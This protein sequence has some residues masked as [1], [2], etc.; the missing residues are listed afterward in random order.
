[1]GNRVVSAKRL[2]VCGVSEGSVG[3]AT[4]FP[5]GLTYEEL[6]NWYWVANWNNATISCDIAASSSATDDNS[7][8][9]YASVGFADSIVSGYYKDGSAI[10]IT[11]EKQLVCSGIYASFGKQFSDSKC[12][13][14]IDGKYACVNVQVGSTIVID[15]NQV[16]LNEGLYYP[17]VH[18][19]VGGNDDLAF[20]HPELEQGSNFGMGWSTENPVENPFPGYSTWFSIPLSVFN[21]TVDIY[22]GIFDYGSGSGYTHTAP[23]HLSL[24]ARRWWE[25][26]GTNNYPIYNPFT[27]EQLQDPFS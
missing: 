22:G 6:L 7:H 21:K 14:P 23:S 3:V 5:I 17:Y 13:D 15:F 25:Y 1:M 11:S 12:T 16:N 19:E 2:P 8:T 20:F 4:N 18:A 10:E 9:A 26:A 24:L 27:G